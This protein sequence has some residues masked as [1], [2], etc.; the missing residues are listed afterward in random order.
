MNGRLTW[1]PAASQ[2]PGV[3]GPSSPGDQAPPLGRLIVRL[4]TRPSLPAAPEIA[5]RKSEVLAEGTQNKASVKA[6]PQGSLSG[7]QLAAQQLGPCEQE[8]PEPK[9]PARCCEKEPSVASPAQLKR[10]REA[11]PAGTIAGRLK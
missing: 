7:E 3:E 8:Q 2:Q 1:R 10:K 4:R 9:E 5:A 11:H 6:E